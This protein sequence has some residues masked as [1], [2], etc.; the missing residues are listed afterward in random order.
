MILIPPA[1][2]SKNAAQ[3]A[4]LEAPDRSLTRPTGEWL[5]GTWLFDAKP[6]D[7]S[8][9]T[10]NP[11]TTVTYNSDGTTQFF[12]GR[13]QW[14]LTDSVLTEKLLEVYERGD[15]EDAAF[16]GKT[17]HIALQ[18]IGPNEARMQYGKE[19]ISILRCRND[20]IR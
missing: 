19:W 13:A 14:Q 3:R 18:R 16:V 10:C 20:E 5:Q 9:S 4:S 2:S 6:A 11:G 1:S 17:R 15:P 7:V 8:R 12:G